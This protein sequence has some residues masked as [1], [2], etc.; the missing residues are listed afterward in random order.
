MGLKLFLVSFILQE[1]VKELSNSLKA[2]R[3]NLQQFSLIAL[4][5]QKYSMESNT[6][7]IKKRKKNHQAA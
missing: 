5:N 2:T 6:N 3:D 7:N 1:S 4:K